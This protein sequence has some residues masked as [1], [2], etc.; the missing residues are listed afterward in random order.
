MQ[1]ERETQMGTL[2]AAILAAEIRQTLLLMVVAAVSDLGRTHVLA[3]QVG[4]LRN[5][6]A[7]SR[8]SRLRQP[9]DVRTSSW[10]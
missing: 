6:T 10:W 1:A 5:H 7:S 8:S 2:G 3:A 9:S 4:P